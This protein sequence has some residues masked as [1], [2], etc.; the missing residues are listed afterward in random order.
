MMKFPSAPNR[1]SDEEEKNEKDTC[2]VNHKAVNVVFH[3]PTI[4][5]TRISNIFLDF[6]NVQM[7][8]PNT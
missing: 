5:H 6:G 4:K 8:P 1:V 7:T 2:I 3:I